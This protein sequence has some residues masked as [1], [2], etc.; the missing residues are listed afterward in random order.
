[1]R[2]R[3]GG[4]D[5][6]DGKLCCWTSS[7][8]EYAID[9]PFVRRIL[10]YSHSI[11][12]DHGGTE[13]LQSISI[14]RVFGASCVRNRSDLESPTDAMTKARPWHWRRGM[15]VSGAVPPSHGHAYWR[16]VVHPPNLTSHRLDRA[17]PRR[18]R[19]HLFSTSVAF[20]R[21]DG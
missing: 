1:M 20:W 19:H 16:A 11:R 13:G 6:T 14:G 4:H 12:G 17:C 15:R 2:E 3:G 21:L 10:T 7:G 8:K 5:G 18:L 9:G